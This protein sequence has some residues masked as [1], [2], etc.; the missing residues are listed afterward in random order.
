MKKYEVMYIIRPE[1][2]EDAKKALVEEINNVF[3][4][5]ASTVEKVDEWGLRDLAYEVKGCTKGYYVVLNVNAT[6]EAIDEFTRVANIKENIIR[7]IAV[8]E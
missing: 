1:L 8:A 7:Y 2:D 3:V 6:P 5:K 4:N